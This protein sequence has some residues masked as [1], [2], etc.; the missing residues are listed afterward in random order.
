MVLLSDS[1]GGV[2]AGVG[3]G[4]VS[5]TASVC[6]FLV[7]AATAFERSVSVSGKLKIISY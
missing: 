7:P 1:S 4:V 6:R 3:V 2:G 5:T